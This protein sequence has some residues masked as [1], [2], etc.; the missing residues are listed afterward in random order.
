MVLECHTSVI[1]PWIYHYWG[2]ERSRRSVV[3]CVESVGSLKWVT[4]VSQDSLAKERNRN[5]SIPLF[6]LTWQRHVFRVVLIW[7]SLYLHRLSWNGGIDNIFNSSVPPDHDMYSESFQSEFLCY[8]STVGNGRINMEKEWL[9][10][11]ERACELLD[12]ETALQILT[13]GLD[14]LCLTFSFPLIQLII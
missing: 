13:L 7:I 8:Q 9:R 6:H 1:Y 10:L 4:R 12:F 2:G 14:L 3:T 11:M 5:F